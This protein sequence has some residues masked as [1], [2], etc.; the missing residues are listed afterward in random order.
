MTIN[1]DP[2]S[3]SAFKALNTRFDQRVENDQLESPIP[4]DFFE[5]TVSDVSNTLDASASKNSYNGTAMQDEFRHSIEKGNITKTKQLLEENLDEESLFI[6][7][8]TAIYENQD[9]IVDLL[10]NNLD[11]IK[12]EDNRSNLILTS[13]LQ[14]NT[15]ALK[16]MLDKWPL[17]L[18]T[19]IKAVK[20]SRSSPNSE[21]IKQLLK[22]KQTPQEQQMQKLKMP[23]FHNLLFRS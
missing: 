17:S 2:N 20:Y 13:T 7:L 15:K 9:E 22:A 6:G 21:S 8:D 4:L 19:K 14:G 18:G 3:V 1:S 5:R 12:N 16:A 23:A 11:E 10:L